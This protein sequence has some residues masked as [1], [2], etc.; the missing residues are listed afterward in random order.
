MQ[1]VTRKNLKL[2]ETV[3]QQNWFWIDTA[4]SRQIYWKTFSK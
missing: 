2:S 1:N 4:S 3:F